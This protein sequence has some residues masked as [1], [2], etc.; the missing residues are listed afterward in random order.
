MSNINAILKS[1]P[2]TA[3][4]FDDIEGFWKATDKL[5]FPLN[6]HIRKL[7]RVT[8]PPPKSPASVLYD[9]SD[10]DF[11]YETSASITGTSLSIASPDTVFIDHFSYL[12]MQTMV[13]VII[14][15]KETNQVKM[16]MDRTTKE[17]VLA[18]L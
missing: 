1:V 18:N 4:G 9:E 13:K 15:L 16:K 6:N 10:V 5:S 14:Q 12:L 17:T 2:K 3:D 7:Y 11:N 8:S